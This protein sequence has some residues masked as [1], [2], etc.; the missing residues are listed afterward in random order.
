V[1]A[2]AQELLES[3]VAALDGD[4]APSEKHGRVDTDLA[5]FIRTLAAVTAPRQEYF[6][7]C[8]APKCA[9]DVVAQSELI[10][11]LRA[12]APEIVLGPMQRTRQYFVETEGTRERHVVTS[13][14]GSTDSNSAAT[15]PKG[16]FTATGVFDSFGM[17][18]SYLALNHRSSL[19]RPPWKV[20]AVEIP[21]EARVVELTSA[22]DW[23]EFVL[24][25]RI[26]VEGHIYPDW[27]SAES[28]W[29]GVHMTIAAIAATQGINFPI[30]SRFVAAPFWDVESTVWLCTR[31]RKMSLIGEWP[32][33][34]ANAPI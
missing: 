22:C 18:W 13:G 16:L 3:R 24:S 2:G 26:D 28:K 30:E 32:E 5:H 1:I 21:V 19:F 34:F 10:G 8:I 33:G 14:G 23:V 4:P 31:H 15:K 6:D 9:D 12:R 27:R 29:D 20:W 7:S 17:W 25:H 11:R